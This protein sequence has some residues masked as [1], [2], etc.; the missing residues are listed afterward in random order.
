M[1]MNKGRRFRIPQW[2]VA[3]LQPQEPIHISADS[4]ELIAIHP[5]AAPPIVPYEDPDQLPGHGR[6]GQAY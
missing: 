3:R 1:L 5:E 4:S 6:F 2:V